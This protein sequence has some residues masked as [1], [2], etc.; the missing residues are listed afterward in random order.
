MA[1]RIVDSG[2]DETGCGRWSYITYA[3]KEG[4]KVVIISAYRVRKHT[5]HGD[6][7]SSKQQ[8]GIMYEEEELWPF[9]VDPHKQKT[10]DLQYFVEK[11]KAKGQEVLILMDS[12][13][14]EEQTYQPQSHNIKCG[15]KK[16]F[17]V[18]GSIDGSLQSFMQNCGLI[19]VL[20]QI[21]E[22]VVSN[23]HARGSVQ[24]DFPLIS[25]GLDEH[26]LD[27]G[28]LNTSVLQSDHSGMFVDLH[29]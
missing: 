21:H 28:L 16:G 27:V 8:L 25:A 22:G 9:L 24:I 23:T 14:A 19:N 7:T 2:Q 4:K 3:V 17:H 20:W 5:N 10:I 1:H 18:D 11:L 26:V 12:N 29:I 13:Q 6:F 15:T